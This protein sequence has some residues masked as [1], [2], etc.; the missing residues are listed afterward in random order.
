[1]AGNY[2][3]TT[4]SDGLVLTANIYNTDHQNHIDNATPAGLDDYSATVSQMKSTADPGED[5]SESQA[6]SMAGEIE[7]LRFIIKEITGNT[8]WYES[9]IAN[10][11]AVAP[12]TTRGDIIRGDSS[13]DPERLALGTN[14]YYLASDGT[15]ALW[16]ALD[17]SDLATGTVPS[18]RI[19]ALSA[20]DVGGAT[21][22]AAAGIV[23]AATDIQI[24][25]A[26]IIAKFEARQAST[27]GTAI[28]F[29]ISEGDRI[30]ITVSLDAVGYDGS[31]HPLIQLSTGSTY[32]TTG[33]TS[34]GGTGG[35]GAIS[36]SSGFIVKG[37]ADSA[38]TVT[39]SMILTHEGGN[40]WSVTC[41]SSNSDGNMNSSIGFVSLGG[42]LDGVRV[43]GSAGGAH[44]AGNIGVTHMG[45]VS[46]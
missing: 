6:T 16:Q 30:Q 31:D 44:D 7:R 25:G 20:A 8:Y 3:H 17:A 46:V 38:K 26:S 32:K 24:N 22:G 29:P 37:P 41:N 34:R 45:G 39:G 1:M 14:N 13:G 18:A 35:S 21:G 11:Q 27:S 42:E 10:L 36:S 33:Y 15:D 2:S 23:N 43:V 40:V 12:I 4:R 5:G 28:S 9:P 19:S